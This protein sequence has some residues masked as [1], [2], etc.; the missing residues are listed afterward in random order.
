[1][2][3]TINSKSDQ[4]VTLMDLPPEARIRVLKK[5]DLKEI[6]RVCQVSKALREEAQDDQVWRFNARCIGG[7][8]LINGK[9]IYE[10]VKWYI[11]SFRKATEGLRGAHKLTTMKIV[12]NIRIWLFQKGNLL[13]LDEVA[14]MIRQPKPNLSQFSKSPAKLGLELHKWCEENHDKLALAPLDE[15]GIPINSVKKVTFN[16]SNANLVT[17]PGCVEYLKRLEGIDLSNNRIFWLPNIFK[18]SALKTLNLSS[19]RLDHF[20]A[21]LCQLPLE[22]LE[23]SNNQINSLPDSMSK[24]SSL[25]SLDISKNSF[26]SFPGELHSLTQLNS[27]HIHSNLI[28]SIPEW[29]KDFEDLELFLF[30]Q[31]PIAE[32][33]EGLLKILTGLDPISPLG[34][35][36]I[37]WWLTIAKRLD[38]PLEETKATAEQIRRFLKILTRIRDELDEPADINQRY[39]SFTIDDINYL[40]KWFIARDTLVLWDALAKALSEQNPGFHY[41]PSGLDNFTRSEEFFDRAAEFTQWCEKH[42]AAL[43]EITELDLSRKQLST[44]PKG[45]RYLSRLQMLNLNNNYITSLPEE[46]RTLRHLLKLELTGNQFVHF[47]TQLWDLGQLQE[48]HIWTQVR[49]VPDQICFLQDLHTLRLNFELQPWVFQNLPK[50]PRPNIG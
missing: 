13:F 21:G 27:L 2:S 10:Q 9:S 38:L 32:L 8:P 12:A 18:L 5:L 23:L 31:N 7:L 34:G 36:A 22:A 48:L 17:V 45:I 43:A 3:L 15:N 41:E 50:L 37:L 16:A 40:K 42:G 26:T 44:L 46:F 33:P 11:I 20:P 4:P 28:S 14:R 25:R 19:N 35:E 24:L 30:Y 39:E 47:P 49:I 1:M 29:I 6:G